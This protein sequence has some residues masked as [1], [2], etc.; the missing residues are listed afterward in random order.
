[1]GATINLQTYGTQSNDIID[2]SVKLINHY[3]KLLTVNRNQSELMSIN[4]AAGKK[5]IQVSSGTY[6]LVKLVFNISKENFGFN[7]L[8]GPNDIVLND[9]DQT[10]FL[11]KE[12]MEL[13]L[14][15]IAKGWIADR[16]R[17]LWHSYG[18]KAGVID[19]GGNILFVGNSPEINNGTWIVDIQNPFKKFGNSIA[20]LMTPE[21]SVVTSGT[22]ERYLM[23]DDCKYHHIID[24]NTDYPVKTNL[25]SV[26]TFTKN[27][28][29]AEIECKR[30][31]SLESLSRI[32]IK[33]PIGMVRFSYIEMDIF[34]MM[35]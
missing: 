5:K 8:I 26:T 27:L 31:F 19:L 17:D 21:S 6:S 13:D 25:L 1:M 35:V 18:I 16:V 15:G 28:V 7:A 32:G 11:T 30:L 14:G 12:G 3:K 4:H 34:F 23:V 2:Q 22:Y 29:Q 10:V 33:I 20:T 9:L 24:P